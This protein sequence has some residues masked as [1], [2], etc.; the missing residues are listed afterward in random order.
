MPVAEFH[1][2]AVTA[3]GTSL[4]LF[5][6]GVLTA[7]GGTPAPVGYGSSAYAFRMGGGSIFDGT[8]NYC[9]A[10]LEELL[11]YRKARPAALVAGLP[12]NQIPN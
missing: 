11:L 12:L 7:T 9:S 3:D 2:V 5:I 8:G 1:H 6:D 10:R 4:R